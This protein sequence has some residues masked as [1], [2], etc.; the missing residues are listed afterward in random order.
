M[1]KLTEQEQQEVRA[2]YHECSTGRH[3]IAVKV[4]GIFGNDNV[5][6]MDVMV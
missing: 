2:E 1:P 5:T 4:V 3:K 6:I